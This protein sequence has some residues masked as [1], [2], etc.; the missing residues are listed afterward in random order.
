MSNRHHNKGQKD[1]GE[2]KYDPPHKAGYSFV[3][4]WLNPKSTRDQ[5]AKENREYN[6]GYSHGRQQKR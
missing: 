4:T 3:S 6:E 5:E 2:R 1:A